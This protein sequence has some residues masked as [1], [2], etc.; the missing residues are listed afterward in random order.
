M[1]WLDEAEAKAKAT[2]SGGWTSDC[3]FVYEAM[4]QPEIDGW[5]ICECYDADLAAHIAAWSPDRVLKVVAAL[6]AAE[7]LLSKCDFHGS[8]PSDED[9]L[10]VA[11]AAL[12]AT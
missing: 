1:N 11:L 12:E 6:R 5:S 2:D 3:Q 10:R 8:H 9:E 4:A 7:T